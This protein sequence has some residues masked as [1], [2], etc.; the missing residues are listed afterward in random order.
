MELRDYLRILRR[1]WVQIVATTLLGIIVGAVV[2]I[3]ATPKYEASTQIYVSVRGD[4]QAVGE[5]AQGSTVARQ[6]VSTYASIATTESVLGPVIEKLDLPQSPEVLSAQ[7]Q[8]TAPANQS[9][10]SVIVTGEDPKLTAQIANEVGKSLKAVVEDELEASTTRNEPSLVSMNTVQPATEPVAP[11]S[12]RVPLNLALGTLLG[13]ALGLGIAVL[14]AVLDTRIRSLQEIE[15]ATD[16]P[17]LGGIT[18]DADSPKRPL[19]VQSDPHSP[20]AEA[21]RTL[22][23]N[24]EFLAVSNQEHSRARTFVVSS[25]GPGEGKSTTATN[26]ALALAETGTRVVLID[27]DLRMPAVARYMGIEGGT[28]LTDLLIGSVEVSDVL[29][30]W[31]K[32]ELYVLPSGK[33]PPNPSELLGSKAM[34]ELLNLLGE[35]FDYI[36]I[37]APPLLL[38]TDASVLSQHASGVLIVA[39]S[40]ATRKQSLIG[41]LD[42]LE[43]AGGKALGIIVTMLPLKGPDSYAYG[44]YGAYGGY[45]RTGEKQANAM[46]EELASSIPPGPIGRRSER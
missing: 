13:M 28:G 43:I 41:A 32:D 46:A 9:L 20:R 18:Y 39:A 34:D 36:I 45:G 23:T 5:L 31:G 15:H 14:R 44:A 21:F 10:I 29:Q 33:V 1:Y 12:P 40:G 7:I 38:V 35:L 30:Q 19:I 27:G 6:S 17:V 11:V 4:G 16:V 24:L 3:T 26:L 37:D 22:R 25:P 42:T 8:A 2:S